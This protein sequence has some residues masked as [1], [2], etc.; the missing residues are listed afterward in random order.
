[1]TLD[2]FCVVEDGRDQMAMLYVHIFKSIPLLFTV[3]LIKQS[4]L[5]IN[6]FDVQYLNKTLIVSFVSKEMEHSPTCIAYVEFL[7]NNVRGG[8]KVCHQIQDYIFESKI[9]II[10][11][12]CLSEI[13][14]PGQG[15]YVHAHLSG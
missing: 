8:P 14:M 2:S 12:K 4:L 1:M 5:Q 6:T 11:S 9:A 13:T 3:Q 15:E 7:V 10:Y